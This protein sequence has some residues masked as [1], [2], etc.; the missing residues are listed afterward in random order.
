MT[1]KGTTGQGCFEDISFTNL[2][3]TCGCPSPRMGHSAVEYGNKMWIYGG[4]CPGT[5]FDEL[6]CFDPATELWWA[7]MFQSQEEESDDK[8][9]DKDDN[10]C[11]R[12][13]D[14]DSMML[15]D[16]NACWKRREYGEEAEVSMSGRGGHSAVVLKDWMYVFGG[17]TTSQTFNDLWKINLNKINKQIEEQTHMK[18]QMNNKNEA[19]SNPLSIRSCSEW[20]KYLEKR[21]RHL[22]TSIGHNAVAIGDKLIF[23]GGRDL[24]RLR[25]CFNEGVI[26]FDTKQDT[27]L[28]LNMDCA[29]RTGQAAIPHENGILFLGGVGEEGELREDKVGFLNL[30]SSLMQLNSL[31]Q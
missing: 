7:I 5:A 13:K 23:Y 6:H 28:H 17:N 19:N 10:S 31:K 22:P 29:G 16:E 2:S 27:W 21:P 8:D 15:D 3:N 26:I 14:K 11:R 4:S 20:Y 18:Q 24:F 1:D 30:T 25:N 12:K 9:D